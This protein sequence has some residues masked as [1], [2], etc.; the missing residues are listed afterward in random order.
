MNERKVKYASPSVELGNEGKMVNLLVIFF[1]RILDE[2]LNIF[3]N[4]AEI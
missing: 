2:A 1:E 4:I 3:Q